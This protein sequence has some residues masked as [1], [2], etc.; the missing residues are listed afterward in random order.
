[1]FFCRLQTNLFN[2]NEFHNILIPSIATANVEHV[3]NVQRIDC[4]LHF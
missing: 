2:K 1:M 4:Y 3:E